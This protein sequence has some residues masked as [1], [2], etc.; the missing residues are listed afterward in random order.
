MRLNFSGVDELAI[1]EGIRRIGKVIQTQVA[2]YGTLTGTRGLPASADAPDPAATSDS[3]PPA[4][5]LADVVELPRRD[6]GPDA[7]RR[8]EDR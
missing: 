3:P 4:S 1:R 8:R 6:R 7:A 2:M 5:A